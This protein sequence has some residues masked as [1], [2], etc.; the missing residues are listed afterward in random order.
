MATVSEFSIGTPCWFELGTVDQAAAKDFYSRIFGWTPVDLPSGPNEFYTIFQ[1]AGRNAGGA[2]ALSPSGGTPG[3][4]PR[5]R[6]YFFTPDVDVSTSKVA[7]LGGSVL[8]PP[9]DV[10]DVGRMSTCKDPEGAVFSLWQP[11]KHNGDGVLNE[12]GAVGWCELATRHTAQAREFYTGLFGWT[13]KSSSVLATYIEFSTDGK[14]RGGLLPMGDEWGDAES[15]WGIY[16]FVD[17]CDATVAQAKELGATVCFGPISAPGVGRFAALND[18]QGATFSV[19][20]PI[21]A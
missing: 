20:T 16:I 5:W 7:E 15:R 19:I 10:M 21:P 3:S 14:P 6:V 8:H 4:G 2:Y 11:K 17:D 18:P 1:L 13:T 12:A 9:S